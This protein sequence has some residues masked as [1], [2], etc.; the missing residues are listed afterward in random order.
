MRPNRVLV[1]TRTRG[2]RHASIPSAIE[3]VRRIASGEGLTVDA[4]EDAGV[5][6]EATLRRYRAVV[7]LLTTGDVLEGAQERALEDYVRDGG[8]WA[9][10]HSAADTEYDWPFYVELVSAY[11]NRHPPVQ[12]G[13]VVAQDRSHPSTRGL[14]TRWTRVDEWYDFRTQPRAHVLLTVDERSYDSG[15]M[16]AHH[17]IAWCHLVQGGRA[18]YTAMGHTKES[19]AEPAF[20]RH[21]VGGIRWTAGLAGGVC[22]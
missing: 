9:G 22:R 2:F 4:T 12:R 13:V 17:P 21:L 14:P 19:Y 11:F 7:F 20:V 6:A 3:A 1:F 16:G 10:V 18:W 15:G 5:F 8:G